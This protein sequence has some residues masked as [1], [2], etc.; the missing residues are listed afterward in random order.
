M[1]KFCQNCYDTQFN[2]YN[3]SGY[4]FAF[5]DE[6]TTCLN[7]KHELLSIDFPKLDLRTLTTICNSKEF[8]D[9]MIDL[10]N[11]DKI[12]YQ[13]KMAQFKVQEAQILQARR[14]EEERNVPKCPTCG[15]K[16]IKSISAS[17]RWLS[18]GL[19]GF[20]S[21]KVGKTM[22]CKNCGYKW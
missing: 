5:K 8:I 6:I 21:N 7:C 18:V 10:Y 11:K 13:L 17:S 19:F 3:P 15:S 2:K 12:E 9:A 4:Y 20:G 22:E 1:I 14:E 16:N